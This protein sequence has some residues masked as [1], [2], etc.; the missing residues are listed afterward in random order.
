MSISEPAEVGEIHQ[1]IRSL[2]ALP[3]LSDFRCKEIFVTKKRCGGH[4]VNLE[5]FLVSRPLQQVSHWDLQHVDKPPESGRNVLS[6]RNQVLFG[7]RLD[8]LFMLDQHGRVAVTVFSAQKAAEHQSS[9]SI[10]NVRKF[11][12]D[13]RLQL[14]E[15]NRENGFRKNDKAVLRCRFFIHQ[16]N[17][18]LETC[19]T[20][21]RRKFFVL[22]D[23]ALNQANGKR[24]VR[25]AP[26]NIG[27]RKRK[28]KDNQKSGTSKCNA[29]EIF[30]LQEEER[31]TAGNKCR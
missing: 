9:L 23:P 3:P 28:R 21:H 17:V 5:S 7:V 26:A 20:A 18:T 30:A 14:L 19:E 25:F 15:R 27:Q 29:F 8:D 6:E 31:R 24:F 1:K 2:T 4:A 10:S 12:P 13:F 22:S 11:L 16:S